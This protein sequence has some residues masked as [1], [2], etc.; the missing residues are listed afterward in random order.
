[1]DGNQKTLRQLEWLN[2]LFEEPYIHEY[3]ADSTD[4]NVGAA[5]FAM[6]R[7]EDVWFTSQL[8]SG[9][10]PMTVED[11][12]TPSN[13]KRYTPA[14]SSTLDDSFGFPFPA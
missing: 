1:M 8:T 9:I 4:A 12:T 14:S 7:T 3:A 2:N 5:G 13:I 6:V 10:K 11:T